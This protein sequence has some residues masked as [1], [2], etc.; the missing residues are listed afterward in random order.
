MVSVREYSIWII[1]PEP[2][3]D[4][5]TQVIARLSKQYSTLSFEPH[6]TLLGDLLLPEED[7][8]SKTS[9]LA[10]LLRPFTLQL[11]TVSYLSEYFRCLFIKVEETEALMEANRKARTLFQREYD[12][13]FMPHLSL[14]YG[15]FTP[16][17]KEAII[18]EIG[19]SFQI[20]FEVRSLHVVLSSSNIV[21][22]SWRKL[23]QFPFIETSI[24]F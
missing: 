13:R 6:V 21:P 24:N 18:S 19:R 23:A 5:L 16:E 3:N 8:V 20:P 9:Q 12:P 22:E 2:F 11:T 17:K 4:R 1:P 15:N 10:D 14:L 7:M